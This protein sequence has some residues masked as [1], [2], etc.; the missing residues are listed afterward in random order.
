MVKVLL[1]D[2]PKELGSVCCKLLSGHVWKHPAH[3]NMEVSHYEFCSKVSFVY[4]H[5]S[6]HRGDE[7]SGV[8]LSLKD[9]EFNKILTKNMIELLKQTI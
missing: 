5:Q 7:L 9:F 2:H 1:G 3:E 8:G 6:M 4:Y